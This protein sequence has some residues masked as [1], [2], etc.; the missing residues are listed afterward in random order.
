MHVLE[1]LPPEET[2]RRAVNGSTDSMHT[3]EGD[4]K[5]IRYP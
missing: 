1:G 3:T 5:N 4:V 2:S